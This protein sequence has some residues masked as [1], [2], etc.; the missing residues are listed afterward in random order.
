MMTE[1]VE[2]L[3]PASQ[4]IESEFGSAS[5]AA[6]ISTQGLCYLNTLLELKRR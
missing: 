1:E 3:L 4:S 6:G 2:L 5:E